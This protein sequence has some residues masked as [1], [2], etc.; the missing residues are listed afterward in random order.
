MRAHPILIALALAVAA[1][2]GQAVAQDKGSV[3]AKPLPPLDNPKDPKIGAKQ[4]FARKLLPSA[5]TP[6]VIGSYTDGCLAGGEQMPISGDTWQVMRLS[7][8]RYWGYP[9]MIALLKR[10]SQKAHQDAGWPGIL[11]GD[12]GQPRGGPALS[13]HAS[14]Q[15]GIDADIWLT[16]MPN[17]LLSRQEREDMS[18]TMIVRDD[19]LDIDPK[20]WTPTHW[21]VIRDAAQEPAVQR[22][23]VNAAI[24]KAL[25][26]E[27]KGDRSWL[28]KVRPWWGHD[29][30]F[31][32]RMRCPTGDKDCKG[33][34]DQGGDDGCKPSELAYWFKDSII[35]PKPQAPKPPPKLTDGIKLSA[36]PAACKA[37][38]NA[39]DS[40]RYARQ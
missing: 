4:L 14:H 22:I 28:S 29:Y 39:P 40:K 2:S 31:H 6:K 34:A 27:A 13:G 15:I 12:I 37:V 26:R 33:Q 19:R 9:D 23:F 25:C 36:M 5:Q 7:R 18:A 11:V 1:C 21:M 30:H 8:N 20:V 24:K 3:D 10:L 38:L 17:R 16:P 35:H 32:I